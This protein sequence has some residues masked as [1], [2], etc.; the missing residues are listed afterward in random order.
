M[1][2]THPP[3][4][5][6]PI[7]S[8]E[9]EGWLRARGANFLRCMLIPVV[10]FDERASRNNQARPAPIHPETVDRYALAMRRGERFPPLVAY[11]TSD[12]STS[13]IIISGNHRL[14]A[15][16]K[17]GLK[18]L[19]TYVLASDTKPELIILLTV[20]ANARHGKEVSTEWRVKQAL[21]LVEVGWKIET[22]CEAAQ[23]S[24][25]LLSTYKGAYAADERARRL[26]IT[27]FSDLG[28]KARKNLDGLRMDNVFM[29]AAITALDTD[30]NVGEIQALVREI[31]KHPSEAEQ[32]SHIGMVA[33]ERRKVAEQQK[34]LQRSS[35]VVNNPKQSLITGIGKIMHCDGPTLVRTLITDSEKQ[36]VWDRLAKVADKVLELQVLVEESMKQ[37]KAG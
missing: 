22:A 26:K 5:P 16:K 12:K 35:H 13:F 18:G 23:I 31:K 7:C 6:A 19:P 37:E 30:M 15:G 3:A 10:N 27:R 2:N 4:I 11:R 29:Q 34:L 20:E 24:T 1:T 8:E 33:D 17:A 36:E 28:V 9:V 14:A 32:I 25:Q 21:N